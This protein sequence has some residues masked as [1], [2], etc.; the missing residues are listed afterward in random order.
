MRIDIKK[1]E[2]KIKNEGLFKDL[3]IS[4]IINEERAKYPIFIMERP[5]N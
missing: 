2:G 1:K 3:N 4:E 5:M